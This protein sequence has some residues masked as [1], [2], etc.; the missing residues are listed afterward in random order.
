ME[1]HGDHTQ[2]L[3]FGRPLSPELPPPHCQADGHFGSG[4]PTRGLVLEDQFQVTIAKEIE[5]QALPQSCDGQGEVP[6]Q[7]V[8]WGA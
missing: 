5:E 7:H 8:S 1:E 2:L 4:S 3:H 6:R